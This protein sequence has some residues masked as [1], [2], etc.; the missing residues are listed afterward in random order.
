[1]SIATVELVQERDRLLVLGQQFIGK[2][3]D[4]GEIDDLTIAF[5]PL[6]GL[7]QSGSCRECGNMQSHTLLIDEPSE[8]LAP[9]IVED[10]YSVISEMIR[11]CA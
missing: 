6:V 5:E 11:S 2:P 1:M 9:M 10:V 3:F 4:V 7:E 8:G